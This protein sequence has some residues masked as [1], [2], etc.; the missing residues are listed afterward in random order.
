[1]SEYDENTS[2]S[3]KELDSQSMQKMVFNAFALQKERGQKVFNGKLE[4]KDIALFCAL[5]NE[6]ESLLKQASERFSLSYRA[7]NKIK[8]VART[9]A[10]LANEK[11]ISKS[12]I[13]E[14]L[15]YRRI[16]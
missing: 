7:Q 9:I 1:M 12:H 14:A 6:C 3:N 10:D 5:D 16:S 4:E 11:Y 15:S 2:Q 8:K 13:L